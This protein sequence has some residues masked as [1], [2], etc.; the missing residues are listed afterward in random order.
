MT[1]LIIVVINQLFIPPKS[2]VLNDRRDHE[3]ETPLTR[4]ELVL[5]DRLVQVATKTP[6][7]KE[8]WGNHTC[9][10]HLYRQEDA[11]HWLEFKLFHVMRNGIFVQACRSDGYRTVILEEDIGAG[12]LFAPNKEQD[13]FK[14]QFVNIRHSI[15]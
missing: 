3:V 15:R 8:A 11:K 2:P 13:T 5:R 6:C 4:A 1:A 9:R 7:F 12:G 14:P 10:L